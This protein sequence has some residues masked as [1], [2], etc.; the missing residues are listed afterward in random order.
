MTGVLRF[1]HL[2]GAMVW[3]GG[4]ITL[5]ALVPALRKA[6]AD[7]SMLQAVARQF[8]RVSW[9]AFGLA[10][11]TGGWALVDYLDAPGLPWKLGTVALAGGLAL[12]HQ[13]GAR[14]QSPRTRGILQ[15]L[16]LAASLGIVAAA[17][18]L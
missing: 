15:G 1:F 14:D 2:L 18:N 4:L 8:G 6:G 3:V 5:G 10:V 17:V 7:R 16:I 11:L 9:M 12:W 13:L